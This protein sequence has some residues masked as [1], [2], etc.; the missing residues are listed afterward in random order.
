MVERMIGRR[1]GT[2]DRAESITWIN[3][4]SP[5]FCR[6]MG[7][8]TVMMPR[9]T[10]PE[11]RKP[12]LRIRSMNHLLSFTVPPFA[13]SALAE[14]APEEEVP[15][16]EYPE[17]RMGD[18]VD[19]YHGVEVADP[20]RWLEDPNSEETREWVDKQIA[21]TTDWLSDIPRRVWVKERLQK[22]W[23]YERFSSPSKKSGR[24]FFRHNNGLQDHSI[25]YTSDRLDGPASLCSTPI[26]SARMGRFHW[27]SP[28]YPRTGPFSHT[29]RQTEDQTGSPSTFGMY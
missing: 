22:L 29:E 7:V 28:P 2:G 17:A 26:H 15:A 11:L 5:H 25:L 10:L 6:F 24:Y 14:D 3:W 16:I 20:Y 13:P 19:T 27:D 1:V 4:E 9:D 23:N 12:L 18:V 21:L 8:R